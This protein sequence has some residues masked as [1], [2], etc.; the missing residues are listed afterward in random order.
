MEM[1][2]EQQQPPPPEWGRNLVDDDDEPRMPTSPAFS[3]LSKPSDLELTW[4]LQTN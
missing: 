3:R 4:I 1:M 2:R